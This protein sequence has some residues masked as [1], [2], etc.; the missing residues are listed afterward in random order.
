MF[1]KYD[2]KDLKTVMT[3]AFPAIVEYGFVALVS[4]VD[5]FMVST[6]GADSVAA[7]G[8]TTQPRLVFM[9][10]FLALNVAISAF[11]ARRYGEKKRDDANTIVLTSIIIIT[12]L[13]LVATAI[14]II[15]APQILMLCGATSET[16]EKSTVYY[17]I[18][19]SGIIFINLGG[20][21]N[22][23]QRGSGNT[24]ITMKTNIVS[25]IVNVIFNFLL[26]NGYLGFP[27]MG[28]AGAAVATV[29]G[30]AVACIMS[31]MSISK[32]STFISIP[33]IVY[34]KIKPS[35]SSMI[36]LIKFGSNIFLE[37]ILMRF[38]F[39]ATAI[40]AAK[41]G[42]APMAAHQVCMNI[43]TLSFSLGDG[44]QAT[45][46][47]LIGKSL[48]ESKPEKAK[49]YGKCCQMVGF[50]MCAVM[51]ILFFFGSELIMSAF[52][53][54][55]EIIEIGT[56]LMMIVILVV[57]FQ[58]RQ[59]IYNGSLKAAGDTVYTTVCSCACVTVMR[60]IISYLGAYALGFGIVG[61]WFGIVADQA[62]RYVLYM[63]RF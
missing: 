6:T 13:S 18:L 15:W 54:E 3:M 30:A 33:Y 29:L 23:A 49:S 51:A 55:A 4:L 41:Q 58:V 20:A 40:M 16:I 56:D 34:N 25:N 21:V 63:L 52:F 45:A 47:A 48:G 50:I 14:A 38:G 2:K 46:I 28:V 42:T 11:T 17:R 35:I 19:M 27:K 57:L 9:S 62:V 10:L 36:S 37:Q 24:R 60:P 8:L 31:F 44:M 22:S 43:L 12:L 5:S 39:M 1:G 53:K 26:I 61:V 32:I 59:V 7:V